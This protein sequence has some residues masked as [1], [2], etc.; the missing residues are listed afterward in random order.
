MKIITAPHPTLRVKAQAVTQVDKKLL[1]FVAELKSTL[2][3]TRNPRGVGLAAPQV[4]K[5]WRVF[6]TMLSDEDGPGQL[7]TKQDK[8]QVYINPKIIKHSADKILGLSK[9]DQDSRDEG[10]LSI[11]GLYGPVPR[12]E[13]IEIEYDEITGDK[14]VQ[15]QGRL[16]QFSARVFQHELDHLDGILFIDHSLKYDLPVYR[17]VAP[18]KFEEIDKRILETL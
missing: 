2:S 3:K 8:P 13:W 14:L 7:Q 9:T 18:E 4:N 11:P 15:K 5:A 10:C 16:S 17:E 1:Q 6:S 12:W